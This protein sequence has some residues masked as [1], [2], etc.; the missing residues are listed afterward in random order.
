[1][2]LLLL[3]RKAATASKK[4]CYCFQEKLLLHFLEAAAAFS[5]SSVCYKQKQLQIKQKVT[6]STFCLH[7]SRKSSIYILYV[8][9]RELTVN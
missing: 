6:P 4:S 8:N 1:M 7:Y 3:P 9:V 5:K 2:K